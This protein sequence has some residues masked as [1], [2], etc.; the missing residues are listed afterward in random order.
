MEGWT[1]IQFMREKQEILFGL[2]PVIEALNAG[3]ELDK[4]LIKK[5][6]GGELSHELMQSIRSAGIP[7]QIVPA[8]KLNR[9]TRKNH[10]GVVAFVSLIS[11]SPIDE[12]IQRIF[13]EGENPL[14]VVLDGITDVRNFGAIARSAEV[15]GAH[16]V[17]IP[18]KG[19][20]QI[21]ADAI[22]TSAGALLNIPVC[23]VKNL[24]KSARELQSSGLKLLGATEK[25]EKLHYHAEMSGPLAIVMGSEDTGIS[26]EL[27]RICDELIKIPQHGKIDSLNVSS[28]AAVLLFESE[29]QRYQAG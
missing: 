14:V 15:A 5:G 1:N 23:R 28:A 22:K 25:A 26:M 19:G 3:T 29:R 24:V 16:A 18:E 13:E 4:V 21:N 27:L 2:R 11:Y 10:Q 8:E 7:F 9:I 12:I 20:A 6:L 17:V